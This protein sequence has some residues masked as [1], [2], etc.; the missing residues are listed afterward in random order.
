LTFLTKAPLAL[1]QHR[2]QGGYDNHTPRDQQAT[3]TGWGRRA[4]AA[5]M[6]SHE[7]FPSFAAAV[8]I[9]HLGGADPVWSSWLA[10]IFIAA[11]LVYVVLYIADL[12]LIRSLVWTVGMVATALLFVLPWL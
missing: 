7:A 8:I 11:R 4:L 5:H 10:L 9:A 6:N 12:A 2:A 3:L 1:A